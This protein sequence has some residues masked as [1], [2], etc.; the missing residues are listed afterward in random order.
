ML[1]NKPRSTEADLRSSVES[2][3]EQVRPVFGGKMGLARYYVGG[4]NVVADR[5]ESKSLACHLMDIYGKRRGL[6]AGT[7]SLFRIIKLNLKPTS[8]QTSVVNV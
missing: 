1:D 7:R 2:M 8:L 4:L 6:L 3:T 5:G